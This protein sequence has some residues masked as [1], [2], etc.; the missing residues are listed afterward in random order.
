VTSGPPLSLRLYAAATALAEPL[1][2]ALLRRRAARGKE[3]LARLG[4]RLG[5][6]RLAR[7]EGPLAWLHGA[8]VG[9]SLALLPLVEALIAA[10]P[11]LGVLVTS[12]T[13]TSAALMA[14]RLPNG[15]VHQYAP[16]DGPRAVDRFLDC[17]RPDLAVFVESELWP[18]LLVAAKARGVR[19]ALLSAKLSDESFRGWSRWPEAAKRLWG[20]F[21]LLLAQ[22]SGR[23]NASP[24]WA[25]APLGSPT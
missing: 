16:V 12:G 17:W 11:G 8:S 25:R 6:S 13:V 5:R 19:L 23:S 20:G 24:S 4:E 22:D 21:D 3:D 2:P 15:A 18:N 1:A 10:R 14:Q 7:P 9:E